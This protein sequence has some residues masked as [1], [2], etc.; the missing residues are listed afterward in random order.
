MATRCT[1][2]RSRGFENKDLFRLKSFPHNAQRGHAP[3]KHLQIF[4]EEI[5]DEGQQ[6]E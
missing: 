1:P 2:G 4:R 6:R 3:E 5:K